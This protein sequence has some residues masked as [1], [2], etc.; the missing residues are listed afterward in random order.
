MTG[1]SW[2]LTCVTRRLT[3]MTRRLTSRLTR[4]VTRR[5]EILVFWNDID[6]GHVSLQS[7]WSE[8]EFCSLGKRVL[9]SIRS[10]WAPF[11]SRISLLPF[12]APLPP[13]SSPPFKLTDVKITRRSNPLP[14]PLLPLLVAAR[15]ALPPAARPTRRRLVGRSRLLSNTG[16]GSAADT[17]SGPAA[18]ALLLAWARKSNGKTGK[19]KQETGQHLNWIYNRNPKLDIIQTKQ[20]NVKLWLKEGWSNI[21]YLKIPLK[22][23]EVCLATR[24][25]CSDP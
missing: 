5:W 9:S 23:R 17:D 19:L 11:R 2:Q 15:A 12:Q 4:R 1:D 21:Q 13:F 7:K 18:A 25:S 8:W 6:A 3:R 10:C 16:A 14:P 20:L 24:K 22:S